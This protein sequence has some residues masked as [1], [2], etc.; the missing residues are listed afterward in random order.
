MQC[1]FSVGDDDGL[2]EGTVEGDVDGDVLG[3]IDGDP[4][5]AKEG[6]VV[7]GTDDGNTDGDIVGL[8]DGDVVGVSVLSQQVKY[9]PLF[10]GQQSPRINPAC[11]HRS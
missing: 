10:S 7:E 1:A 5:G 8:G 3:E 6:L 2:N 4:L 9:L 11:L